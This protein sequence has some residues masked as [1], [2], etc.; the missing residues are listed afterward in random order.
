MDSLSDKLKS[1][2]VKVG[3]NEIPKPPAR[4]KTG[5]ET[6]VPGE[7]LTTPYGEAFRV[8]ASYPSDYRHGNG[9]LSLTTSLQRMAEWGHADDLKDSQGGHFF[10]LDTETSGLAGGT[11]TY[12]FL[13]GVGRYTQEGF[14]L[15][16][17]FM[18]DPGEEAAML[19]ALSEFLSPCHALVTFNGKAFDVPLLNT[20][21]ALQSLTSP[22]R[23]AAHFDVLML[24]RRIWRDR[25]ASR[26]LGNLE[27]EILGAR[28][29][30]E[31]VPGWLIPQFYFDY[32]RSGDARPLQGV[33][34]HNAMDILSLAALFSH[35]VRL[36]ADPLTEESLE[37]LDVISLARLLEDMGYLDLAGQ[38][39]ERGLGQ[40]LPAEFAG[41]AMERY[42]SM[43]KRRGDWASAL[44]WWQKAAEIG[45]VEAFVE[46]AKYYEHQQR[47]Y[48]EAARW[49]KEA[50]ALINRPGTPRILR[51]QYQKELQHRL[52]RLEKRLAPTLPSSSS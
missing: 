37:S 10:F 45:R 36:L 2:G 47:D 16:Q 52:E 22:L 46:L 50:L 24:A 5:I 3:A 34:Y 41:T 20:R 8:Q 40:G 28:R 33:F 13:V 38:L 7:V 35:T 32:L 48:P 49:T 9:G 43:L 18:R 17:F 25:L 19:A 15:A 39:F 21:Y 4:H 51:F 27:S 1:L 44:G 31:E 23:E 12:A 30:Q 29:T 42:A 14:Q 6:V 26:T 11:G